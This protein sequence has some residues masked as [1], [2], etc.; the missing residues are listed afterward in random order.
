MKGKATGF[1]SRKL[2]DWVFLGIANKVLFRVAESSKH[3][4]LLIIFYRNLPFLHGLCLLLSVQ[5][6]QWVLL[7]PD[8]LVSWPD[9]VRYPL[10]LLLIGIQNFT[11]KSFVSRKLK[12][13]ISVWIPWNECGVLIHWIVLPLITMLK[14][15][16]FSLV[17]RITEQ[18]GLIPFF[19]SHG[20]ARTV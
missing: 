15:H 7:Q 17:F 8:W 18:L 4:L 11:W 16:V 20:K 1:L 6:C 2:T 3:L 13:L 5:L 19:F 12:K 14:P 9:T 10:R